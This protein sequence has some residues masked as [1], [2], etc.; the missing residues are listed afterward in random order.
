MSASSGNTLISP[1]NS[2]AQPPH[3]A[4]PPPPQ[5]KHSRASSTHSVHHSH[6]GAHRRTHGHGHG[7]AAHTSAAAQR[8]S[9]RS[10]EGESGRRALAAGLTMHVLDAA[11]KAKQ[12]RKTS[13]PNVNSTGKV[14]FKDTHNSKSESH[15]PSLSRVASTSSLSTAS[16]T[17]S[18]A[19]GKKKRGSGDVGEVVEVINGDSGSGGSGEAEG[20]WESGED[21]PAGGSRRMTP[22]AR[23]RMPE[24]TK[25]RTEDGI[26]SRSPLLPDPPGHEPPATQ[27]VSGFP[28]VVQTPLSHPSTGV[29]SNMSSAHPSRPASILALSRPTSSANLTTS[30][31]GEHNVKEGGFPFPAVANGP[32]DGSGISAI[33]L[34]PKKSR[35]PPPAAISAAPISSSPEEEKCT[36]PDTPERDTVPP[37]R[38]RPSETSLMSRRSFRAPPH[39]LNSLG[40]VE[41]PRRVAS[42]HQTPMAE[43]VVYR[44]TVEGQGFDNEDGVSPRDVQPQARA[45][46]QRIG[47]FSSMRSLKDILT[48]SPS[49]AQPRRLVSQSTGPQPRRLTAMQATSAVSRLNTTSDPVAYHQSLGFSPATAETAHLLSR[50]LPTRRKHRPKW[51]I[52]A[53][54]AMAAH[55]AAMAGEEPPEPGRVGLTDGQYRMSHESLV[56]TLRELGKS[57]PSARRHNSRYSLLGGDTEERK[58]TRG[59]T[60]FELSAQRCLAQR[61]RVLV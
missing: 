47:S 7:H 40:L 2:T 51:A 53:K 49:A 57:A 30:S 55:E 50:F 10:S 39:P 46:P 18:G 17:G 31:A 6:H 24:V 44:E 20:E 56:E 52:T 9:R 11:A 42:L 1:T 58:E 43:A 59:C 16:G 32:A 8:S 22:A 29:P 61:P 27:K 48:G 34:P 36:G 19:G 33:V 35:L 54:E 12:Q 4:H 26:Q 5:R 28:P 38:H 25:D 14:G 3:A 13:E 45:E 21:T 15:L 23:S 60:P 37:L 41:S